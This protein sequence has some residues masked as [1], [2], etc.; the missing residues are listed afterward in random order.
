MATMTEIARLS[1]PAMQPGARLSMMRVPTA[2]SSEV[3]AADELADALERSGLKL[4]KRLPKVAAR[5]MDRPG[6]TPLDLRNALAEELLKEAGKMATPMSKFL[7]ASVGSQ[8]AEFAAPDYGIV[9]ASATDIASKVVVHGKAHAG[10]YSGTLSRFVLNQVDRTQD[11]SPY[12]F[13]RRAEA[14]A[15]KWC[16]GQVSVYEATRKFSRHSNC[17]CM[18]VR[19]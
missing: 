6:S 1:D 19:R 16:L 2:V 11:R 7:R 4:K 10:E 8:F 14:N 9:Y 3:A 15:C 17:R 18:K 12:L 5:V 13:T